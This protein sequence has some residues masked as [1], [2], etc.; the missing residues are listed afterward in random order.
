MISQMF[1][2]DH[3]HNARWLL[4]HV[5]DLKCLATTS[6]TTHAQCMDGNCA[7]QKT[8]HKCSLQYG[9]V[10]EQLSVMIKDDGSILGI[11]END[12]TMRH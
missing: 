4:V 7:T 2:L 3:Y 10:H 8:S 12:A 5:D 6:P 11:T 1:V 9:Q